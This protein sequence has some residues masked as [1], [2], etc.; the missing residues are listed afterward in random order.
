MTNDTGTGGTGADGAGADG[1][2]T[3]ETGAERIAVARMRCE[4]LAGRGG[5]AAVYVVKE[6]STGRRFA[7][8]VPRAPAEAGGADL[9]RELHVLRRVR[10]DHLVI[11]HGSV[12]TDVGSGILMEYLPG[13]SAA[14]LVAVRGP[15]DLGEAVTV[16]APV[17]S[18]LAHLHSLG[19]AHGDVSPANVLFTAEGLPKLGDL[20]L[21]GLVGAP[22]RPGG[23]PGFSAPEAAGGLWDGARGDAG[24]WNAGRGDAALHP[25]RDVYALGALAWFLLTGRTPAPSRLRPP[26]SSLLPAAPGALSELI[27]ECLSEEPSVRPDAA[28]VARRL[29]A[30]V[31]PEPVR[32]GGAVH[33]DALQDMATVQPGTT[34]PGERSHRRSRSRRPGRDRSVQGLRDRRGV[35]RGVRRPGR[36]PLRFRALLVGGIALVLAV[37]G[38]VQVPRTAPPDTA[39]V[40]AAP[41][42]TA[43]QDAGQDAGRDP[44]RAAVVLA[45]RRDA[46]LAAADAAALAGVHDP[47]GTSRAADEATIAALARAGLR[48]AGL[49]TELTGLV[50]R[51]G[52]GDA[53]V[54]DGPDETDAAGGT[55]RVEAT[56]TIGSYRVVDATGATVRAVDAPTVQRLVFVL[57]RSAGGWLVA[58]VLEAPP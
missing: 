51:A 45:S 40:G 21:A 6:E 9:E 38:L 52:E 46:A 4:R 58:S 14:D 7:V 55:A 44:L 36:R 47:G 13:G 18:A 34:F 22:G 42:D 24:R 23:T 1:S 31:V 57:R 49:R 11:L 16:L 27:E 56:S 5:G 17:A 41:A 20:G 43:V 19:I 28:A 39:V 29:F 54:A 10:H 48:Y 26:L 25:E 3:G 12:E 37:A 50:L 53:E 35:R 8:K 30:G 32:L 15:V 2:S 33:P